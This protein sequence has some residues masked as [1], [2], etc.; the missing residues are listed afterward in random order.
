MTIH[1][2]DLF[3]KALNKKK[4]SF[5]QIPPDTLPDQHRLT[6]H[7]QEREVCGVWLLI[8]GKGVRQKKKGVCVCAEEITGGEDGPNVRKWPEGAWK[9]F[10]VGKIYSKKGRGGIKKNPLSLPSILSP[11]T[12]K[13]SWLNYYRVPLW[14]QKLW[15]NIRFCSINLKRNIKWAVSNKERN[16]IATRHKSKRL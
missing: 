11:P 3:R 12:V 8:T 1:A 5:L 14:K 7:H 6:W 9:V 15:K 16:K 2:L 13:R 4:T 10:T